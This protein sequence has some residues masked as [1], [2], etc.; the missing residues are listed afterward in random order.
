MVTGC[1]IEVLLF[2]L[3]ECVCVIFF[4]LSWSYDILLTGEVTLIAAVVNKGAYNTFETL[5]HCYLNG[6]QV[7]ME[8][9]LFS[10]TI[11]SVTA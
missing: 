6:P 5:Y 10:E 7:Y 8:V 3:S 4:V 1:C 9:K 2:K 11:L